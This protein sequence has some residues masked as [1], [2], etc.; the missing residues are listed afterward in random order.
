MNWQ[1]R[2]CRIAAVVAACLFGGAVVAPAQVGLGQAASPQVDNVQ[3]GVPAGAFRAFPEIYSGIFY[4][5]NV[6]RTASGKHS[7]SALDVGGSLKLQSNWNNHA[8][9]L[10]L[11]GNRLEYN[12]AARDSRTTWNVG[13]DGRLDIRRGYDVQGAVSYGTEYEPRNSPNTIGSIEEPVQF[14]TSRLRGVA[15][16]RPSL[17]GFEVG[18][19]YENYDYDNTD[20]I[21]G[22]VLNNQDRDMSIASLWGRA[23]YDFSPGYA[24][25]TRVTYNDRAF[26]MPL[27]RFG[28]D[29]DSTGYAVDAGV[30]MLVTNLVSGNLYA[31]WFQQVYDLPLKTIDGFNYGATLTWYPSPLLTVKLNA[32]RRLFDTTVPGASAAN[33]AV[34][35][36]STDFSVTY[37]IVVTGTFDYVDV[38]YAGSTRTDQVRVFGAGI[39]YRM[40]RYVSVEGRYTYIQRDSSDVFGRFDSNALLARLNLHL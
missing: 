2:A 5:D 12:T 24:V 13:A 40:N 20:L 36:L 29:R 4:D 23:A 7:D 21:G 1:T 30:D 27:D 10:A 25:F 17:L 8:L 14:H 3:R 31:G 34:F 28:F 22:G 37:T 38:D 6:Y 15:S 18:A 19:S 33:E 16:L 11:V 39:T 9:N 26:T 32:A 35:G